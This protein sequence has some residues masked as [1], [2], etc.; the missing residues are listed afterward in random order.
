M[1]KAKTPKNNE[2]MLKDLMK[3]ISVHPILPALLRERI[4]HISDMTRK[5]IEKNPN[6]FRTPMT[7]ES[8]YLALCDLI[9]KHLG[10]KD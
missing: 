1:P 4:V 5:A 6:A 8:T 2:S 9:D 3:A 7:N 10:F